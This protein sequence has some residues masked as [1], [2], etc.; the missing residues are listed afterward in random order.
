MGEDK[1]LP[2]A[3]QL[4]AQQQPGGQH[5]RSQPN[6]PVPSPITAHT[7]SPPLLPTWPPPEAG[8]DEAEAGR[9]V[10]GRQAVGDVGQRHGHRAD[11]AQEDLAV[12]GGRVGGQRG[13][14]MCGPTLC[15]HSSEGCA[16]LQPPNQANTLK[17]QRAAAAAA[18]GGGAHLHHVVPEQRQARGEVQQHDGQRDA[19]AGLGRRKA[20]G[21][22]R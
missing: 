13:L 4:Q 6:P 1:A 7:H 5:K 22:G 9:A 8:H 16:A 17:A 19:R 10:A 20:G 18:A 15:K 3:S 14:F 2:W 11:G 12:A 21:Q